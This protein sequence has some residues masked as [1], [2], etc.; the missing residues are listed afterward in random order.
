[1]VSKSRR[2]P[3]LLEPIDRT[4]RV[5][6]DTLEFFVRKSEP[7][8]AKELYK[9]SYLTPPLRNGGRSVEIRLLKYCRMGLLLRERNGR[10]YRYSITTEGETR[11]M[12]LWE[13]LG[14][15]TPDPAEGEDGVAAV[16]QRLTTCIKLVEKQLK[17]LD[18]ET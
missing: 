12:Y 15:L 10:A 6:A 14:Y 18:A 1:M 9:D 16:K 5:K 4:G 3:V 13:R 17:H 2:Y 7:C 11:L 8:T